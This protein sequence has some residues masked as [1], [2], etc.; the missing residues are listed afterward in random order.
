MLFSEKFQ[1]LMEDADS[2]DRLD[3]LSQEECEVAL[4]DMGI[5][6]AKE[7]TSISNPNSEDELSDA[8]LEGVAGGVSFTEPHIDQAL[9]IA[10]RK[11]VC[12]YRNARR[13]YVLSKSQDDM[14]KYHDAYHTFSQAEVRDAYNSIAPDLK[15]DLW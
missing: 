8:E 3:R 2:L 12:D 5:D 14:K 1:R 6:I 9:L 11:L 4:A 15:I 7:F 13:L 10:P